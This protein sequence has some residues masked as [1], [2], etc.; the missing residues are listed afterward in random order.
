MEENTAHD[1]K[2]QKNKKKSKYNKHNIEKPMPKINPK[3][4]QPQPNPIT[5]QYPQIIP[6]DH[7]PHLHS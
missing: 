2:I 5:L 3:M 4:T 6:S 1:L 7:D